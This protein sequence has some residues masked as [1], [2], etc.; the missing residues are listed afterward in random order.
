LYNKVAYFSLGSA[1]TIS[2]TLA[3]N[4]RT[5][6][7][8]IGFVDNNGGAENAGVENEGVEYALA[9]KLRDKWD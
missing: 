1:E 3:N 8:R 2:S 9:R 6:R 7:F 4:R 5:F